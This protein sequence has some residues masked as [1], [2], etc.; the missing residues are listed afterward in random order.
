MALKCSGA[1]FHMPT[2][3]GLLHWACSRCMGKAEMEEG[4][5]LSGVACEALSLW[6]FWALMVWETKGIL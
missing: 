3:L 2:A 6:Q 4:M 5:H 1:E